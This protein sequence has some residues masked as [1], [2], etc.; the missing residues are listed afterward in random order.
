MDGCS[1]R[2]FGIY[3][4]H[5]WREFGGNA[6]RTTVA[7]RVIVRASVVT[8]GTVGFGV[9]GGVPSGSGST[10]AAD[11][12][13]DVAGA[14]TVAS[15]IPPA[16]AAAP[17]SAPDLSTPA[18]PLPGAP[19]TTSTVPSFGPGPTVPSLP[20]PTFPSFP[21]GIAFSSFPLG[22]PFP[23]FPLGNPFPTIP[24]GSSLSSFGL[25]SS[26]FPSSGLSGSLLPL[27]S[28]FALLPLGG[29]PGSATVVTGG[30]FPAAVMSGS[31]SAAPSDVTAAV[32]ATTP[33]GDPPP[34]TLVPVLVGTGLPLGLDTLLSDTL[35]REL[36]DAGTLHAHLGSRHLSSR[37][38]SRHDPRLSDVDLLLAGG[39]DRDD[40]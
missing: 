29:A 14:I 5:A 34:G 35:R 19:G 27:G 17:S 6:V 36:G 39:G 4:P 8:V 1:E 12:T 30:T 10:T 24:L 38:L 18:F 20:A 25:G 33:A 16:D 15:P 31:G 13:P 37:H 9:F 2:A 21:S 22:S 32:G 28:A 26:A 11:S 7:G 40:H 23:G 3:R